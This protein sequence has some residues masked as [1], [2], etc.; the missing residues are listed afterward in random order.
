ME[1]E[2]LILARYQIDFLI[3]VA[4][5]YYIKKILVY[6]NCMVKY[7]KMME[8][9]ISNLLSNDVGKNYLFLCVFNHFKINSFFTIFF[10]MPEKKY[11]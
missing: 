4:E 7:L 5:F 9:C 3:L 10:N 2:D 8:H 6:R 1:S 11:M